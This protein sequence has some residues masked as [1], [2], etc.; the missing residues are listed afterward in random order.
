MNVTTAEYVLKVTFNIWQMSQET[1]PWRSEKYISGKLGDRFHPDSSQILQIRGVKISFHHS[2]PLIFVN[3]FVRYK[4]KGGLWPWPRDFESSWY[5]REML[6]WGID[7]ISVATSLAQ[8]KS[9]W[10]WLSLAITSWHKA[11]ILLHL[12]WF[13]VWIGRRECKWII[14]LKNNKPQKNQ[15]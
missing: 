5:F 6:I 1:N 3:L 9:V 13:T 8:L 4:S 11:W 14:K 12:K 10:C 2:A 15:S 7:H